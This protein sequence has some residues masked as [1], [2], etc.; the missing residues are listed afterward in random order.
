[1]SEEREVSN[2]LDNNLLE[3]GVNLRGHLTLGDI[4]EE[5]L[6][7]G[8]EVLLEAVWIGTNIFVKSSV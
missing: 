2:L 1:M 4:C 8:L 7:G 3:L 6:L 5:F